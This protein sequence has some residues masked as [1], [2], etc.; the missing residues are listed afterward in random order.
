MKLRHGD[1]LVVDRLAGALQLDLLK[2]FLAEGF[3][4]HLQ[5]SLL[6]AVPWSLHGATCLWSYHAIDLGEST[7]R[8]TLHAVNI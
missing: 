3:Q 4:I 5:V 6:N 1:T 2:R 8:N 7:V